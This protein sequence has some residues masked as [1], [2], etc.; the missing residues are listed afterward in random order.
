[1]YL[2]FRKRGDSNKVWVPM[3]AAELQKIEASVDNT[4]ASLAKGLFEFLFKDELQRRPNQICATANRL[5][6]RELCDPQRMRAIRRKF[7]FFF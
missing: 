6:G 1:M 4:A 7:F 5:D 3:S 2:G